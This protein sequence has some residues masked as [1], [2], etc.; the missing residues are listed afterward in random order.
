MKIVSALGATSAIYF[1][2]NS[3]EISLALCLSFAHIQLVCQFCFASSDQR[4]ILI[5]LKAFIVV[6]GMCYASTKGKIYSWRW[7][8]PY[9]PMKYHM[10][11]SHFHDQF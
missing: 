10:N 9:V 7:L 2:F 8:F 5:L 3:D 4:H 11:I 1:N 6:A